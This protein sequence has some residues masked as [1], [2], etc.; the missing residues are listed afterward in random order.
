MERF[1]AKIFVLSL[2][3]FAAMFYA[4]PQTMAQAGG[5]TVI[6]EKFKYPGYDKDCKLKFMIYGERAETVGVAYK[7][8][9]VMID[10]VKEDIKSVKDVKDIQGM[11]LYPIGSDKKTVDKFWKKVDHSRAILFTPKATFETA[12]K[13]VR[14]KDEIHLRAREIDVDGVGFD[15]DYNRQIINIRSKVRMVI[16]EVPDR[17]KMFSKD[18]DKK[19]N[20][21]KDKKSGK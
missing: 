1:N 3:V 20:K 17:K 16:R 15:A 18:K 13:L 19:T 9:N 7:L 12:T 14:G 11:K 2:L 4:I 6:S 10:V 21:N 8:Q 5:R